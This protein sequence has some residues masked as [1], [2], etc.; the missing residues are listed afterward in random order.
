MRNSPVTL[1][2]VKFIGLWTALWT[3]LGFCLF[4]LTLSERSAGSR[5]LGELV[6]WTICSVL[7][8]LFGSA[9]GYALMYSLDQRRNNRLILSLFWGV[10][11]SMSA[12]LGSPSGGQNQNFDS[13]IRAIVIIPLLIFVAPIIA[14]VAY[15]A[16]TCEPMLCPSKHDDRT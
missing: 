11:W 12:L 15:F 3:L 1:Q 14:G 13:G 2:P 4:V 8:S 6:V 10:F 5:A 16:S 9:I 7:L